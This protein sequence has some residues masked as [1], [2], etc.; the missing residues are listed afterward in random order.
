[1]KSSRFL[2]CVLLIVGGWNLAFGEDNMSDKIRDICRSASSS[3]NGAP[4]EIERQLLQLINDVPNSKNQGEVYAAIAK[5]LHGDSTSQN[6]KMAQYAR[7]A[8][9][10]PIDVDD[11]CDMYLCL[12]DAAENQARQNVTI[13]DAVKAEEQARPSIQGL[14]FVL[15]HLRIDKPQLPPGVG[16]YDV[17]ESDPHYD[18]IVRQHEQEMA[19]REDVLQQN[20]LLGFRNKFSQRV[21]HLYPNWES[22]DSDF[23]GVV[24]HALDDTDKA[25]IV[26]R[27]FD[28]K[29]VPVPGSVP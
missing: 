7:E 1:M 12:S 22:N 19:E 18:E 15:E 20:R 14:A 29:K 13:P 16:K 9:K 2:T 10:Y 11:A 24:L 28:N 5:T 8:L 27:F 3:S 23:R 25:A 26:I 17:P 4:E 6:E 21:F